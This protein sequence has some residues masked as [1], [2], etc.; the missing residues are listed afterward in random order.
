MNKNYLTAIII[1]KVGEDTRAL[2]YHDI[3]NKPVKLRAFLS[4]AAAKPGAKYVNFYFK[5]TNKHEK[6]RNY[7]F[8]TYINE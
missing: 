4:F 3:P 2:K 1:C 5:V 8:R 6:G 7:A